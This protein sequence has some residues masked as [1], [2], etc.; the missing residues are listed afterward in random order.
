MLLKSNL[1]PYQLDAIHGKIC[2]YCKCDTKIVTEIEVYGK[3]YSNNIVIA[4]KNFPVCDAYVGTHN[5]DSTPLGRLA[6][7]K[8]R[9]I[10][11]ECKEPFQRLWQIGRMTR[12]ECYD[13]LS[14]HLDLDPE[15]THFGM[16][17][18]EYCI[19][20]KNWALN[21]LIEFD[22]AEGRLPNGA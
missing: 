7:Q 5:S 22:R 15:L 3:V 20:A 4:C 13:E 1:T 8:L 11:K 17:G 21:K 16:F 19:K 14:K 9:L 6:R 12:S 2:P 18:E 10:K